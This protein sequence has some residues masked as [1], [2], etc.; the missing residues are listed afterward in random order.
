MGTTEL[1]PI[2]ER[3]YSLTSQPSAAIKICA[4]CTTQDCELSEGGEVAILLPDEDKFIYSRLA[5]IDKMVSMESVKLLSICNGLCPFLK[6]SMCSIHSDRPF[7]CRSYPI[8][9]KF[10]TDGTV[11][12]TLSTICP[13]RASITEPFVST[14]LR[15]WNMLFPLLDQEWRTQYNSVQPELEPLPSHFNHLVSQLPSL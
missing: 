12:F 3:I 2:Y 7:D 6:G 14:M 5:K 1:F 13:H 11:E 9:P 4:S 8:V 15:S 10:G